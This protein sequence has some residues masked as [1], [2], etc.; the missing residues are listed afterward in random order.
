MV[1]GV[2]LYV[3]I[4]ASLM[5]ITILNEVMFGNR[6]QVFR[7]GNYYFEFSFCYFLLWLM[8]FLIAAFR[9]GTG[10]DY[11]S[12]ENI[13]EYTKN[14]SFCNFLYYIKNER[15][16]IGWIFLNHFVYILG[17]GYK[18]LC[19]LV[20]LIDML[21]IN[22]FIKFCEIPNKVLALMML[23]P[24]FY[25]V[26]I[27]SGMRQGM[28]M[29]IFAG[30]M[31]R[32][33]KEKKYLKYLFINLIAI[34]IHT[35]AIVYLVFLIIVLFMEK[36]TFSL[37]VKLLERLCLIVGVIGLIIY[38]SG[39]LNFIYQLLP[40]SISMHF[41]V[42]ISIGAI[43]LRTVYLFMMSF[44]IRSIECDVYV[45]VV[46]KLYL[47]GLCGFYLF[48]GITLFANRMFL[49]FGIAIEIL[50]V[51]A[52]FSTGKVLQ[53]KRSFVMLFVLITSFIFVKNQ[54]ARLVNLNEQQYEWYNY[55]YVS[56]FEIN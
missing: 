14:Y 12:Y 50:I 20:A 29:S 26:F 19:V 31:L 36:T 56:F 42:Q 7:I 34:S 13:F 51:S 33:L 44:M 35:S 17:F 37:S 5:V 30:I 15:F 9:Y 23:F 55:P 39:M 46:Y 43:V 24:V 6:K 38:Y 8:L 52:Y 28:I 4:V 2:S 53:N 16:E 25:Y 47:I 40:T 45:E 41:Y 3:L 21:L 22:S 54:S 27:L 32:A 49:T 1:F 10:E 11:Y 18:T 48:S